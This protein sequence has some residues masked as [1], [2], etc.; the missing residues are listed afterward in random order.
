LGQPCVDVAGL[1]IGED[2][3]ARIMA[4]LNVSPESFYKGSVSVGVQD[5]QQAISRFEE[6][7]ADL[8]DIG[9]VSTAPKNVYGTSEVSVEK[10]LNRITKAID[11]ITSMTEIPLSIDTVSSVV[12]EEALD[13]GVAI[14]NDV[15]GLQA[16]SGMARLVYESNVPVIL[17]ANCEQPCDSVQGSLEAAQRSLRIARKA[18]IKAEKIVLDPGIGFGKPPEVDYALLQKI[19][20]FAALGHPILVGVSR[21]AFIGSLLGLSEPSDRLLGSIAATSVAVYNGA[22]II[23]THD[24]KET[25]IGAQIGE[26]VR[27]NYE[28]GTKRMRG[29]SE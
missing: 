18:A 26:A 10:E 6:E 8:I 21:K 1:L 16:D 12:A 2:Y 7:G 20:S 13:R 24:V 9:G 17:M 11:V 29:D 3:P 27:R 23:R 28:S 25:R 4:V 15:S 5:I 22:S 19:P 14:I